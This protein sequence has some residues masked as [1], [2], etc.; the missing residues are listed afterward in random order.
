MANLHI[1]LPE[2]LVTSAALLGQIAVPLMLFASGVRRLMEGIWS[3]LGLAMAQP[4]LSAGGGPLL[5]LAVWLLP[6]SPP[7]SRCWTL[8]AALPRRY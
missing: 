8:L 2:Y 4:A 6:S 3:H 1:P 7:G 5:G